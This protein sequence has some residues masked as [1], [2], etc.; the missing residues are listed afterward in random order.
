MWKLKFGVLIILLALI[1]F[2][3]SRTASVASG[4]V[5]G[6]IFGCILCFFVFLAGWLIYAWKFKKCVK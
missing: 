1:L 4:F 3:A 5:T 2:I 6:F